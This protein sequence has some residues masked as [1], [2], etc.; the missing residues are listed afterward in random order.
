M[1]FDLAQCFDK[2]GRLHVLL[3][4]KK[5]R[6]SLYQERSQGE[7][8]AQLVQENHPTIRNLQSAHE[9]HEDCF[10]YVKNELLSLGAV[11]TLRPRSQD[12]ARAEGQPIVVTV[13]GDGTVLEASHLATNSPIF[14]VNSDPARSIGAMCVATK[15]NFS[16]LFKK[17]LS[18]ALKAQAIARVG[19]KINDEPVPYYALNEILIAH[20]NPAA[21]TRYFLQVGKKT[22]EQ[23]SSGI[24]ISAPAGST[25]AINSA[26]GSIVALSASKMQFVVREPCFFWSDPPQLLGGVISLKK[27][28]II[29]SKMP[30][31]RVFFDGP[32]KWVNFPL[33]DQLSLFAA[34]PTWLVVSKNLEKRRQHLVSLKAMKNEEKK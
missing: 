20:A 32:Y 26:G 12:E 2:N 21:S 31:G 19:V 7:R 25:G 16:E 27:K 30:H 13:G 6:L 24:W 34:P 17:F 3:L 23:L 11:V 28:F 9:A 15:E 10:N 1:S 22:E 29:S 18:G 33:G 14:G 5:S 4:H 8:I